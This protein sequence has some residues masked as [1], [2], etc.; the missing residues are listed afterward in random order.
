MP[1]QKRR[2]NVSIDPDLLDEARAL[3]MNLSGFFEDHLRESL[4]A[5]RCR[6]WL[7]RN[8]RALIE[9]RIDPPSARNNRPSRPIPFINID[10]ID[11]ATGTDGADGADGHNGHDDFLTDELVRAM[12][13]H[14]PILKESVDR[15][16]SG[17]LASTTYPVYRADKFR[18]DSRAPFLVSLQNALL[19]PLGRAIVAPLVPTAHFERPLQEAHPIVALECSPGSRFVVV[20]DRL[21]TVSDNA[22]GKPAGSLTG[23]TQQ[24]MRAIDFVFGGI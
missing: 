4:H 19:Q 12:I 5:L 22:L 1:L 18:I 13:D 15:R 9:N 6:T 20:V 11:D 3:E 8:R 16:L 23:E 24:I 21:M 14:V 7:K 10:D 2:I 17:Q